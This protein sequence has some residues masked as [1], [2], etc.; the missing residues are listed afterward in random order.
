MASGN[1]IRFGL[2]NDSPRINKIFKS[3]DLIGVTPVVITP[4]M[5][6]STVGVFTAIECKAPGWRYSGDDRE[7][8]QKRFLDKVLELGG[9][10]RFESGD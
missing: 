7:I 10:A 1:H 9:I 6:G 3:S 2:G 5:V 4:E 8:A